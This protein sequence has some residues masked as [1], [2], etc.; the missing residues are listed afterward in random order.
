[1]PIYMPDEKTFELPPAGQH[2]AICNRVIDLGTQSG[3]YGDKPTLWIGWEL[4]DER[5]SGGQPF[6]IGRRYT[7]SSSKMSRLRQDIEGWL[8][9]PLSAA[10]FGKL[11]LTSFLG[12]TCTLAIR[13]EPKGDGDKAVIGAVL[14]PA[15]G[16]P[17]RMS[18]STA[19]IALS[20]SDRPFDH[21]SYEALPEILKKLIA[22]SREYDKAVNAPPEPAPVVRLRAQ[23]YPS[24][25][26][27]D[28]IPF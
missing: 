1:M 13:H 26:L 7:W 9:R 15:K 21:G 18:A 12:R 17:E 2:T 11:D 23:G 4:A 20:L 16:T 8:Q 22:T 14:A 27:D 3:M 10:D 6:T 25:E 19:G 5:T 28:D 24:K